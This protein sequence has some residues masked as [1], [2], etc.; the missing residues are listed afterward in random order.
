M[1]IA[2]PERGSDS[3][4]DARQSS[5]GLG[6]VI[7]RH[8]ISA[9]FAITFGV[10]WVLAFLVVSPELLSGQPLTY[11]DGIFMF[12]LMLIG[13]SVTGITLTRLADGRVGLKDLSSRMRSWRLG[14]WYAPAIL[15][16]PVLTLVVLFALSALVS[17]VFAPDS[18]VF[19]IGFGVMAGYLE[20]IGWTGYAIRKLTARYSA[21]VSAL[22]LGGMWGLWHA[23][24]VDFLGAAYPHGAYW[25]PFYL[26]FIAL[27][28]AVRVLIVWLHSNTKSVLVAQVAHMSFTGSLALLAPAS[29]SPAQE[30]GWYA[31]YACILWVVVAVVV[32]KYGTR[33]VRST[34]DNQPAFNASSPVPTMDGFDKKVDMTQRVAAIEEKTRELSTG[35]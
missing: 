12:P 5:S 31:V 27:V 30:A 2:K 15:T 17:G 32:R 13:P 29:V 6:G 10:S 4:D 34:A 7:R 24:V 8:P 28:I 11:F 33:L 21:F 22:V 19:G 26:S 3:S 25:L 35:H 9:Y 1:E 20:E 18:F 14:K 23:P 16:F